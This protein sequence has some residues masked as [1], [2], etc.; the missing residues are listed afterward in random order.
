VATLVGAPCGFEWALPRGTHIGAM[1]IVRRDGFSND[2]WLL[3]G[4]NLLSLRYGAVQL[5]AADPSELVHPSG[6]RESIAPW[7]LD[8]A[9][10]AL[11][12][13]AFDYVWLVDP[14]GFDPA[15]GRGLQPVWRG[16][17][18]I[19]YRIPPPIRRINSA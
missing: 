5:F 8:E 13:D 14:P 7:S 10:T 18:S 17:D 9:L 11:P 1:V 19:L 16:R 12:R 2:Q 3:Q 15:L 6:C 4:I